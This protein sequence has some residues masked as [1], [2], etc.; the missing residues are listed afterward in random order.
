MLTKTQIKK[1]KTVDYSTT[2]WRLKELTYFNR[3]PQ[4]N[5]IIFAYLL[6]NKAIHFELESEN[7]IKFCKALNMD[8]DV[9][10]EFRLRELPTETWER[11]SSIRFP[12]EDLLAIVLFYEPYESLRYSGGGS[13]TP[14]CINKLVL[15]LLKVQEND[16]VIDL[17]AGMGD[18]IVDAYCEEQNANYFAKGIS[19][20]Q[21]AIAKI[22]AEMLS[23][24]ITIEVSS[25]P[26]PKPEEGKYD[27]A[28]ARYPLGIRL[29]SDN[30]MGE[31]VRMMRRNDCSVWN[32]NQ[33]LAKCI[34]D[35]G[36][37][38][39][40]MPSGRCI[41]DSDK[42]LREDFVQNGLIEAIIQLP[43]RLFEAP[44][45]EMCLVVFSHN[46]KDI[47]FVNAKDIY[48]RGRR[49]NC[50][51]DEQIV[52]IAKMTEAESEN[53][54]RVLCEEL[55][56]NAFNLYPAKYLAK[57]IEI[58]SGVRFET[59]IKK[60]KRGAQI[61]ATMLDDIISDVETNCQYL[62]IANIQNGEIVGNLPYL[63]QIEERYEKYCI[64]DN[65]I[66][67]SKI[68]TPFKVAVVR[69]PEGKKILANGNLYV[70][71]LTEDA[72][73]YYIKAFIESE[74]GNELL[75]QAS[76]GTHMKMISL[77]M[78][79]KM[80]VP[81]PSIE[82]QNAFAKLYLEQAEKIK[83]LQE[84]LAK[85]TAKLKQLFGKMGE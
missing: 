72:N 82:K 2:L 79:M 49:T 4:F 16:K 60:I 8:D 27:K 10:A 25:T 33:E 55:K 7:I 80:Q 15:N 57:K 41:N 14:E 44:N 31:L 39:A 58:E 54:K 26:Y 17:F 3:T 76:A 50:I 74:I 81:K 85:Q 84:E 38:V 30:D 32:F 59:I 35:K 40:I 52:A 36:K 53:S 1:L 34:N 67:I 22:R 48:T 51:T 23:K 19:S 68:G 18:F 77:D 62:M 47:M 56:A 11:L 24:N 12:I 29:G 28:F 69:V 70:I 61:P 83:K 71:E 66:V 20:I 13:I 6:Y 43:P 78:L 73:P 21:T 75:D 45:I 37:A 46:N 64:E 42:D 9:I 63:K 65:N 5:I